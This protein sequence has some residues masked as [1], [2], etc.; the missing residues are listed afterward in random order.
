MLTDER[1]A[2][3]LLAR[4]QKYPVRFTS[5]LAAW[6]VAIAVARALGID[7]RDAAWAVEDFLVLTEIEVRPVPAEVPAPCARA[8]RPVRKGAASGGPEF[9]G[10][11]RLCLRALC[12]RAVALQRRRFPADRH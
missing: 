7:V 2:R 4:A 5:P 8:F 10:L 1:D 9:R 11:L 3:E 12:G 6:E